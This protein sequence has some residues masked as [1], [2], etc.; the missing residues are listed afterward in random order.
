MRPR[1]W[2]TAESHA[3]MFRV[4]GPNTKSLDQ[5]ATHQSLL[6]SP[7]I[8]WEVATFPRDVTVMGNRFGASLLELS[9][10]KSW[11]GG[12]GASLLCGQL[13]G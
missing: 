11:Y 3:S 9:L 10:S 8:T 2:V 6:M 7:L 1:G 13:G 5:D 4:T 12:R